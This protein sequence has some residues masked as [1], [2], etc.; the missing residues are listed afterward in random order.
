MI[1]LC[2]PMYIHIYVYYIIIR[3]ARYLPAGTT[4]TIMRCRIHSIVYYFMYVH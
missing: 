4:K 1:L 3:T 2:T